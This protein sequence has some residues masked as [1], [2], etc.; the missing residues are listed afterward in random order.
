MI[1]ITFNDYSQMLRYFSSAGHNEQNTIITQSEHCEDAL[2][3]ARLMPL[4]L[5]FQFATHINNSELTGD[6]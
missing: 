6:P 4:T 5:K 2:V 3:S 1:K